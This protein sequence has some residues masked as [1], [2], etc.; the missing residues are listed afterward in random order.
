[1]ILTTIP[2]ALG[3]GLSLFNGIEKELRFE[4]VASEVLGNLLTT[5]YRVDYDGEFQ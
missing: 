5:K 3:D 1:M 4:I 2:I